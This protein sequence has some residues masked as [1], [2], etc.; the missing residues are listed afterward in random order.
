MPAFNT[1]RLRIMGPCST[2]R[3]KLACAHKI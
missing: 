1:H 3:F 2:C